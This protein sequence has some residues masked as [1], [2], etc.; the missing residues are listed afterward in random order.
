MLPLIWY[1]ASANSISLAFYRSQL[2]MAYFSSL[3]NLE[4]KLQAFYSQGWIKIGP[5]G[6]QPPFVLKFCII[7]IELK[8]YLYS[9]Q[10]G[11]SLSATPFLIIFLF[12]LRLKEV[13]VERL[14][15]Y[16]FN[17]VYFA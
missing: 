3:L 10:V 13:F 2:L 6:P 9:W 5:R 1:S 8:K 17:L 14:W 15:I 16:F 4:N 12:P 7:F 11:K